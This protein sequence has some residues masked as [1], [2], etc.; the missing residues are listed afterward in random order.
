M[1]RETLYIF[2]ISNIIHRAFHVHEG[3]AT[4][5]G[6]PTGSIYGTFSIL[7]SFIN[8]HHPKHI[9]ICYDWQG[10]G[11]I[12]KDLYP[13]YKANRVQVNAV[14]A[15]EI[16]IRGMLTLL[17]MATCEVPGYEADDLIAAGVKKYKDQY[18]IVIV[19]GDKDLLQLIEPGVKVFDSMKDKY[20]G[21]EE[22]AK[23]FGVRPDQI[24]DFLSI[25]GDKV[26]NIPGVHLVGK[27]GACKLL[28]QYETLE[29]I[30]ENVE[31]IP[32]ALGKRM[33]EGTDMAA[34]SKE[35]VTLYD[36]VELDIDGDIRFNPRPNEKILKM[37]DKLEFKSTTVLKLQSLWNKYK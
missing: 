1:E 17:G 10:E 9:L 12:R 34:L 14:S 33:R 37:F 8:K 5:K 23:K 6:F 36:N 31:H 22:V 20:Y 18:D 4:S 27:S 3:L 7:S 24:C 28:A 19:T 21:E 16:V 2:D 29:K 15:Q 30:Y 35:L 11:S 13:E 26:D 32:G 25:T